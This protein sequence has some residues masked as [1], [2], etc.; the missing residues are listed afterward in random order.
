M[1]QVMIVD[2][3]EPVLDSFAFIL[4]NYTTDFELCAKARSGTEVVRLIYEHSPDL[5]FMDIQMPGING[6]DAIEQVRKSFP[7]T[8][9]ILATAYERFDIA[10]KAILLGVFSY[11]V[12]PVSRKTLLDELSRVK[13]HLDSIRENELRR[14]EDTQLL[15]IT[16]NEET[17]RFLCG[18]MWRNY[19]ESEWRKFLSLFS[20]N[21]DRGVIYL[22]EAS[23]EV[24][25]DIR[26]SNYE[27][28]KEKI[29]YK[30]FCLSTIVA[31]RMLIFFPEERSLNKL[32]YYLDNIMKNL[33]P[34]TF[35]RGKGGVYPLTSLH[36]SFLEA[37]QPFAVASEK[38]DSY[39]SGWERLKLV[40]DSIIDIKNPDAANVFEDFWIEIFNK[41]DFSVAL[42]KM[43]SLFSLVLNRIDKQVL[44]SPNFNI[45]PAEEIMVLN[46]VKEWQRWAAQIFERLGMH[47]QL[48]KDQ[49][50]P[51]PLT[52]AIVFI[53]ENYQNPIQLSMVAEA[54]NV[55]SSYLSRLFKEY[56]GT[57][58]VDYINQ[59]R[60]NKAIILLEGKKYSIKEVSHLVGYQDP[61]YFSRIFRR[62]MGISP[63]DL[64][65]EGL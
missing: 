52:A 47:I 39:F 54:C 13:S 56:L 46:S 45:D 30:F 38:E 57:N 44:I 49:S 11:I 65:K 51:K 5:V 14:I 59:F 8:V 55:T 10:Q 37:F 12:K 1:Y 29:Q 61:N 35:I 34:Y 25:E 4:N 63:S 21:S 16:K 43:V 20:I 24:S 62:H 31:G 6:I 9:F 53:R 3:E 15:K 23:G 60:L 58:F 18:L 26:N 27:N 19:D 28:I 22:L 64:D 7:K 40:C 36:S 42:G 41:L 33:S 2:D 32:D 17:R 48:G 50:Y